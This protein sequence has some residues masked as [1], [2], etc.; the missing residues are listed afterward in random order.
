[1]TISPQGTESVSHMC[2]F[3]VYWTWIIFP[4]RE[5]REG[6]I[7][8]AAAQWT[9]AIQT[10]IYHVILYPHILSNLISYL[11]PAIVAGTSPKL[12]VSLII[13]WIH[14]LHS[15]PLHHYLCVSILLIWG[16]RVADREK[17]KKADHPMKKIFWVCFLQLSDRT[18]FKGH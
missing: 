16:K 2:V 5:G 10:H 9:F 14:S 7:T 15:P 3:A 11:T 4:V 8:Q 18:N 13:A 1:M 12:V 17:V 6:D